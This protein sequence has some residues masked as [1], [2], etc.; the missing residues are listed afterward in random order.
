MTEPS[1]P[2][3][4]PVVSGRVEWLALL[5]NA[6]LPLITA[7]RY[8]QYALA[9]ARYGDDTGLSLAALFI[10][11]FPLCLLGAV[12]AGVSYVEGP[13]WRRV[14]IYL[15]V[16]AF[17]GALSGMAR[18]ALDSELGPIIAW[19]VAMQLVLL[20]F[21]GPQ[22]EL[23]R[24]RI[25]AATGDAVNLSILA[26]FFGLLAIVGALVIQH[27]AGNLTQWEEITFEWTDL[28]FV[29]ALYFVLRA[30]SAAYVYTP[31][32]E[33]RRKGYFQRPWIEWLVRNL[34]RSPREKE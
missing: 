19:A 30:W 6:V 22:P 3:R 29:G 20:I 26:V 25:D 17:V 21:V 16:I 34:G 33:Q 27:F 9:P 1:P 14:A 13:T 4:R 12:F 7:V 8:A 5:F 15:G 18:L 24:A 32:F 23:G 28:A 31:A 2:V 11:Q 10:A